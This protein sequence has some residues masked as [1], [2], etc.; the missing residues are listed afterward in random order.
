MSVGWVP[1]SE[2]ATVGTIV[3][4]FVFPLELSLSTAHALLLGRDEL[5]EA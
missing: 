2:Q 3:A 1:V 5:T 4:A